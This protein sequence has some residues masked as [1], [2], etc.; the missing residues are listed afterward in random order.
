MSALMILCK[1]TVDLN[2]GNFHCSLLVQHASYI[3][4]IFVTYLWL[5]IICEHLPCCWW[6]FKVAFYHSVLCISHYKSWTNFRNGSSKMYWNGHT[7]HQESQ[8]CFLTSGPGWLCVHCTINFVCT[9]INR[10][11]SNTH[12]KLWIFVS[13]M[14]ATMQFLLLFLFIAVCLAVFL[15]SAVAP[16]PFSLSFSRLHSFYFLSFS[17]RFSK[18][19]SS[20]WVF[21][22]AF[23]G[24]CWF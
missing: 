22:C 6:R 7:K 3:N 11:C 10:F 23:F 24:E 12:T 4:T 21:F 18:C 1:I 13:E 5:D 17:L 19:W 20:S 15:N 2:E 9:H 8:F 16:L 14:H